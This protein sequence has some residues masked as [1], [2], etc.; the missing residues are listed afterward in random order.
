[1]KTTAEE[2]LKKHY[3]I[4]TGGDTEGWE[5]FDEDTKSKECMLNAMKEYA[6]LIAQQALENASKKLKH[7]DFRQLD[8]WNN[9]IKAITNLD[10]IPA[11]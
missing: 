1:M 7:D 3:D 5:D 11:I 10:N 4:L 6:Q 8:G 9:S 2:I